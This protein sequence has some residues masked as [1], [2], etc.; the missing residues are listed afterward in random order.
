MAERLHFFI[1]I[2]MLTYLIHII[3]IGHDT[4]TARI[5]VICVAV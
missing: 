3:A 4:A 1:R 5:V 2:T